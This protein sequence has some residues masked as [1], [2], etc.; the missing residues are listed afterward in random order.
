[1]G[2][3]AGTHALPTIAAF[4]LAAQLASGYM[5]AETPRLI[6]LR[7]RLFQLLSDCPHLIPTGDRVERLPHHASFILKGPEGKKPI[8]GRTLVRQLN[9][10]GIGISSGSACQSGKLNP[11]PILKALGYGDDMALGGIRLTLGRDNTIE[12]ID[13]TAMV[14]KQV[15]DQYFDGL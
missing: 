4:G 1:M 14:I 5:A 15:L 11:S 12:D 2:L 9:L 7:D 3:R 6:S 13:W 10:A 8:T